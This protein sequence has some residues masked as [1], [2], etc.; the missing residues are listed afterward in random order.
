MKF[1]IDKVEFEVELCFGG[2]K[3]LA[4]L[5]IKVLV[6]LESP[7]PKRKLEDCDEDSEETQTGFTNLGEKDVFITEYINDSCFF[8]GIIKQRYFYDLKSIRNNF[9]FIHLNSYVH[10]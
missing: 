8:N 10:H 4:L 1:S 6:H 7:M 9:S 2:K 5:V 3:E